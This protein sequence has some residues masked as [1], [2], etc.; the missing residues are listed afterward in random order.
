MV[1]W[2]NTGAPTGCTAKFG[3]VRVYATCVRLGMPRAMAYSLYQF[4]RVLPPAALI[5][6]GTNP[7]ISTPL[8]TL[9][10]LVP[11][12]EARSYT[13]SLLTEPPLSVRRCQL[14]L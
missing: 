5:A 8:P 10:Q 11:P 1:L 2:S 12:P 3:A 13:I 14:K 4:F 9:L 7:V 6:A